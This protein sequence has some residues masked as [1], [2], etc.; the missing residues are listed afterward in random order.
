VSGAFNQVKRPRSTIDPFL[1]ESLL[2][3]VAALVM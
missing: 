2:A 1:E 3:P